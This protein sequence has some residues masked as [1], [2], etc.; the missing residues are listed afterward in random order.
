MARQLVALSNRLLAKR[1]PDQSGRWGTPGEKGWPVA[2]AASLPWISRCLELLSDHANT[3]WRWRARVC[4]AVTCCEV[5][6]SVIVNMALRNFDGEW[7]TS[8]SYV[9]LRIRAIELKW[10][11]TIEWMCTCTNKTGRS[12]YIRKHTQQKLAGKGSTYQEDKDGDQNEDV[13]DEKDGPSR[14]CSSIYQQEPR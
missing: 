6:A 9:R 1:G 4:A 12:R 7:L 14:S 5:P 3:G 10:E 11:T 2:I 13:Y 8:L